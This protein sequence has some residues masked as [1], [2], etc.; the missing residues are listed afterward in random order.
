MATFKKGQAPWNKGMIGYGEAQKNG[1]WKGGRC[2]T[3]QGY[4]QALVS[5]RQYRLEHRLVMEQI[6][7]RKLKKTELVHH[8]NGIKTDNRPENLELTTRQDHAA[9][10]GR[11]NNNLKGKK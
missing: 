3:T 11:I 1:M 5:K 9:H 7:G 2:L 4:T 8:K 10:H 6:L